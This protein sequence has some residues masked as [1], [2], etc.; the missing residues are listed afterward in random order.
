M[1]DVVLYRVGGCVRDALIGRKSKDIDY[2]VEA[3]SFEAM[4]SYIAARGR[5]YLSKPEYLT[6]RAKLDGEDRDFVLCRKDGAYSDGRRP[7]SVEAGTI[8]D[9]LARRDF[10]M[11]AIAI[12]E[13][14]GKIIDPH[15][16]VEDIQRWQIRAVG[17]AVDR[18]MED[19]LRLL[20]AMRFS[21]TLGFCLDDE[22]RA[23]MDDADLLEML[24]TVSVER[25]QVELSKCFRADTFAT[26]DFFERHRRLRNSL[27]SNKTLWIEPTLKERA[28]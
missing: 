4:E 6:I 7:D 1:S 17:N 15:G 13:L 3:E 16:G 21:I 27:F 19:A 25:Q 18:F 24:R 9:D 28:A 10:T 11:N 5:I 26:L 2:S 23:C 20:R 12:R 14:D 8:Y 22:I